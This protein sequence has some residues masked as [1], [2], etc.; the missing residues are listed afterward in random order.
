VGDGTLTRRFRDTA[1]TN[2]LFAKSGAINGVRCL[3][4][5]LI[6]PTT[7]RTVAFSVM[8]NDL[9]SGE[10]SINALRLHE[11]VVKVADEWLSR[12]VAIEPSALGG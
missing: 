1:L 12:Q 9:Q 10:P 4:G 2:N 3:S 7:G 5:Y 11:Q 6:S 8:C